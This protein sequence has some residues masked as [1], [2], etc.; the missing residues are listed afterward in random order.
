MTIL[1]Q[2]GSYHYQAFGL[3]YDKTIQWYCLK[4]KRR[5]ARSSEL[6]QARR[7]HSEPNV[8]RIRMHAGGA[9]VFPRSLGTQKTEFLKARHSVAAGKRQV[10]VVL[11]NTRYI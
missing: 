11:A 5:L 8:P 2:L 6:M 7:G 9:A 4:G 3:R 10:L 1:S